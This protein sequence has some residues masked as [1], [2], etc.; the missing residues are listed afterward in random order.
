APSRRRHASGRYDGLAENTLSSDTTFLLYPHVARRSGRSTRTAHSH[1]DSISLVGSV[2]PSARSA[3]PRAGGSWRRESV[4][5]PINISRYRSSRADHSCDY[6]ASPL[7]TRDS[8]PGE[9]FVGRCEGDAVYVPVG[10]AQEVSTTRED[11]LW[12]TPVVR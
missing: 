9:L 10:D 3:A 12:R 7:A 11:T 4:E 1:I 5:Q 2:G 8:G 6:Q